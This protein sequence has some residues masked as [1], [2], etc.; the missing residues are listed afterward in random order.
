MMAETL[1][2][3]DLV[4]SV[5][6]E[7]YLSRYQ[8]HVFLPLKFIGC[9]GCE[10]GATASAVKRVVSYCSQDRDILRGSHLST[11]L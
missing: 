2:L 9:V 7:K 4:F 1:Y 3:L 10:S 11:G 5:G 6:C 8:C